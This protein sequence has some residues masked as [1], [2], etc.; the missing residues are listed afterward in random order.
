M[1]YIKLLK[2]I[3][4]ALPEL[5]RLIKQIEKDGNE[6]KLKE[7]LRAIEDAFKNKDAD[8]LNRA[9]NNK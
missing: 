3:I 5:I 8:A 4:L 7:D 6:K 9:F 1:E 2:L